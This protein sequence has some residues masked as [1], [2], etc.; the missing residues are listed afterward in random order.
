MWVQNFISNEVSWK[1]FKDINPLDVRYLCQTAK[2]KKILNSI[3]KSYTW[4]ARTPLDCILLDFHC[5]TLKNFVQFLKQ[6][7]KL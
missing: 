1:F 4:E 7:N 3:K 5:L 6:K 2:F